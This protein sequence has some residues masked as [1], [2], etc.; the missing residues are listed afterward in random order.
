MNQSENKR[1]DAEQNNEKISLYFSDLWKGLMKFWWVC[2]ALAVLAG[3]YKFVSGRLKYVPVYTASATF[4]VSTENNMNSISGVSAYSF[5]YDSSTASQLA[6]TFPYIL[7]SNL[8][9]EAVC[10]DMQ[11]PAM[12]AGLSA[13]AVTGSNM[14]TMTATG[15]DPQT[16]YDTLMSVIKNYPSI[17]KYVVGN[18]KLNMISS[19]E[20]PTE[21]SNGAGYKRSA[22]KW[23]LYGAALGLMLI[24]LYA[25]A[26]NTVRTKKDIKSELNC[27]ALGT[28]PQVVFK[29]HKM[30][31]DRAVL[32][33]N[34]GVGSGF[35]ESFRVL[36]NTFLH[37]LGEHDKVVTVTSTAPGEGKTTVITNLA[38]SLA[39]HDKKVLLIDA[40]LRHPSVAALLGFDPEEIDYDITAKRYKI[41]YLEKYKISFLHILTGEDER[42]SLNSHEYK[43][44]FDEVKDD[45]DI[46]LVDTP[47]CGL[48][49]DTIFAAQ[50]SDGAVYVVYQD[51]VRTSKIRSGLNNLV[52]SDVKIFGCVLNGALSG[53][54]GYGHGYGYGYGYKSYGKY[55]KYGYGYGYYGYGYGEQQEKH[56]RKHR[57]KTRKGEA[58]EEI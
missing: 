49:S 3:G 41:T 7:G 46:V 24:L 17:A 9:Q 55:G 26:R 58:H 29:K 31:F 22:L 50:V 13:V 16:T 53:F 21:P 44:I 51:T 54:S 6:K 43:R 37:S 2:V 42:M 12:P 47:P 28:V 45:Y 34:D 40:D 23:S 30:E 18:I 35:K 25:F 39:E 52:A 1:Q 38:L 4:T 15:K 8:L 57:D 19:P 48:V 11:V 10:E 27:E 56:H 36:R 5:Y 32:L 33:T 14:F 20:V